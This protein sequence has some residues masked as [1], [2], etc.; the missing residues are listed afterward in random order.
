MPSCCVDCVFLLCSCALAYG[1]CFEESSDETF[2]CL[3][4]HCQHALHTTKPTGDILGQVIAQGYEISAVS[5]LQFQREQAEEFLKVGLLLFLTLV[6][7][8]YMFLGHV[9]FCSSALVILLWTCSLQ[10]AT[11]STCEY[12]CIRYFSSLTIADSLFPSHPTHRCTRA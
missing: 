4:S 10:E 3:F 5:A 7:C 9:F 11:K 6:L 12:R 2:A 1:K 8:K